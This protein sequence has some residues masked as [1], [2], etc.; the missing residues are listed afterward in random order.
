MHCND[1]LQAQRG[2]EASRRHHLIAG[3]KLAADRLL[4]TPLDSLAQADSQNANA[5]EAKELQV[6]MLTQCI[7]ILPQMVGTH[8]RLGLT[9]CVAL[10]QVDSQTEEEPHDAEHDAVRDIILDKILKELMLDTKA[11]VRSAACVWLVA[12]CTFTGKP[13]QLLRRLPEIQEAFSNLLGDSSELAQVF[14]P[15]THSGMWAVVQYARFMCGMMKVSRLLSAYPS[16]QSHV[17]HLLNILRR[18]WQSAFVC[19]LQIYSICW[20][21][22]QEMASRGLSA[23]YQLGDEAGRAE[24]LKSLMGTLQ[25]A[26]RR[27]LHANTASCM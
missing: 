7:H 16:F 20:S 4:H 26:W 24:L 1:S 14:R 13:P 22:V 17:V 18:G 19:L 2:Q 23:V 27:A 9:D 25:G 15:M 8:L 12:L 21:M 5:S 6:R 11:E 10:C 3:V